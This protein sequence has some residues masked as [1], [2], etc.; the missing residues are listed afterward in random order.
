MINS[1][2]KYIPLS[3]RPLLFSLGALGFLFPSVSETT[4]L[5]CLKPDV[6]PLTISRSSDNQILTDNDELNEFFMNSGVANIEKWISPFSSIFKIIL[7]LFISIALV[8]LIYKT[9][10]KLIIN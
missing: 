1:I 6:N 7:V 10:R 8:T 9:L 5:F 4:F 2:F 3:I